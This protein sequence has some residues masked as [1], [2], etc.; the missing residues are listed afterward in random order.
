[1]ADIAVT[2]D[3]LGANVLSLSGADA[4]AFEIRTNSS[5]SAKE[6]SFKGGADYE[7]KATYAVTVAVDD[8]AVGDQST[9][10]SLSATLTSS[11]LPT[12]M[13]R[14]T[15]S[16]RTLRWAPRSNRGERHGLGWHRQWRDL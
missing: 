7:V 1:V 10:L 15:P 6:P 12:P 14:T 9:L 11:D 4:S 8:G 3:A 5:T 16:M 2:D 13:Q